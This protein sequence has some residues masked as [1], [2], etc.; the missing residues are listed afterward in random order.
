[1]KVHDTG[2]WDCDTISFDYHKHD[3]PLAQQL[4]KM[5]QDLSVTSA[6]D[7]GCGYGMYVTTLE[8]HGISCDCYD[9][10][11]HT[12]VLTNNKCGVLDLSKSIHLDKQYDC[13]ISLEVGEH[14]P[15]QYESVFI[16]NLVQHSKKWVIV[17][18]ALPHQGG[19]GHVNEQPNEYIEEKFQQLG[20]MRV[21]ELETRL[22]NSAH[23]WWFKNTIMVFH[24]GVYDSI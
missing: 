20:F 19:H 4:S 9:G 1:M 16:D 17:S 13:V 3:E 8:Q 15:Q 7:F 11:P 5:L 23:W 12:S 14:I 2:F 22:R 24:L 10:N 18:W 6:I 21:K